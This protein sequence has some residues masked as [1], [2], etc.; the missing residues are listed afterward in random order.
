MEE[1][2]VPKLKVNLF[3]KRLPQAL[4]D[5]EDE[6]AGDAAPADE[7]AATAIAV[8]LAAVET[9]F[10]AKALGAD[11][12]MSETVERL[13]A[14]FQEEVRARSTSEQRIEQQF[15]QLQVQGQKDTQEHERRLSD[16]EA[17]VA[18]LRE[19]QAKN[20][21]ELSAL[22]TALG[23]LRQHVAEGC[24]TSEELAKFRTEF[25]N[26]IERQ[27]EQ[28]LQYVADVVK[29]LPAPFLVTTRPA[30]GMLGSRMKAVLVLHFR[31]MCTACA[32]APYAD[33]ESCDCHEKV[34]CCCCC[35]CCCSCCCCCC[36]AAA[37]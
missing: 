17:V 15:E 1:M 34:R 11:A 25:E 31:C 35:C 19:K 4:R 23:E 16:V 14:Q 22:N 5:L 37:V 21:A 12:L 6:T 33:G 32:E 28:L 10:K 26:A 18:E 20:D 29:R 27:E 13:E 36:C 7:T 9:A 8:V 3:K 30:D 24:I 2:K